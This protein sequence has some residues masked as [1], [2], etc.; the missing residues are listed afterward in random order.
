MKKI[1][2]NNKFGLQDAVL[3]GTKTQTRRIANVPNTYTAQTRKHS[4]SDISFYLVNEDNTPF[5]Y[6]F[7]PFNIDDVLA[8]AQ[9]YEEISKDTHENPI[10]VNGWK[11]CAGWKNKMFV[12]A[13]DM[14]HHIC[15][16]DIRLDKLQDISE[17]DCIAEG[18]I[19]DGEE[20]V[21][22]AKGKIGKTK[23]PTAKEAYSH[24]I[25]YVSGKGTWDSNPYV[26]VYEFELID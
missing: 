25:D 6:C 9:S 16:T 2:F 13:C 19:R 15:I 23:Y 4:N 5:S 26:F 7:P 20:Y 8:I 18:I 14:I 24:L 3:N 12:K 17:E 22:N 1:M 11:K 21:I 10:I